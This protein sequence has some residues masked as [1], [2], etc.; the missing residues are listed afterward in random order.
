MERLKAIFVGRPSWMNVLMVF[1][2]YMT[3]IYMPFDLFY[4]P[5]DQDDEVWFGFVL[6]G[7]WAKATEP[8]HWFIYGAGLFGFLKMKAWMFPWASLYAFQVSIAMLVWNFIY[9][10]SNLILGAIAAAPFAVLGGLL[11]KAK[12]QFNG[13][14][15]GQ[16]SDS[17]I[18]NG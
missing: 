18:N 6:K 3:F 1:C 12:P 13:M 14:V 4:K 5:I 10:D 9:G 8:L 17:G 16:T 2:A 15:D 7:W 11:W